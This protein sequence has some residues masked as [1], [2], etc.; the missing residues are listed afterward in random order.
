MKR[1]K[2]GTRGSKLALWQAQAVAERLKECHPDLQVETVIVK[3][4]GDKILDVALS[5]I[6]DKGLFTKELEKA[7]L[8]GTIDL[9]VHSL[10]DLPSQLGEELKLAAVMPRENPGDV[11]IS[12][13][14]LALSDLPAGSVIGTSSLR[15]TAQLKAIRPDLKVIDIR[16]NVETRIKKMEEE[17][18]DGIILAYAGVKR[19][20]LEHWITQV[21]PYDIMLPATGQGT[22][23]IETRD[24]DEQ[25]DGLL[26]AVNDR[27]TFSE[28]QAERAFL[29]RL[30]G[31]CQVPMACLAECSGDTIQL[32]GLVS[33]LDGTQI[34]RDAINGTSQD[35]VQIGLNLAERILAAGAESILTSIQTMGEQ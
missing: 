23:A 9:A 3:T 33:S 6:G 32:Q 17:K 27:K 18:L 24:H 13:S 20:G 26:E 4:V 21:L 10:K 35:P 30:E 14:G 12:R 11:L 34:I 25:M 8:D 19:L 5:R 22:I 28:I 16:G 29:S 15:R 1:L 7:L 2:L 31:G